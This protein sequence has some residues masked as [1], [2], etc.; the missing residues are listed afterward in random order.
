MSSFVRNFFLVGI[1]FLLSQHA[2]AQR[3]NFENVLVGELGV[4][5]GSSN[6]YGDLNTGADLSHSKVAFG[7]FFRKQFGDYVAVRLTGHYAQL[8]YSDSYSNNEFQR[9]R[10]LSF[11][12]DIYEF[13]IMGDFNFLRYIPGDPYYRFTPYA[14]IGVGIF[15]YDPYTFY[16]GDK[17]Y[18]RP[19]NTE[20]Q[21]FYQDR[22]AYGNTAFSFP[23]AFGIKYAVSDKITL[24]AEL[25]YR[26]TTTDYIDDVSTSFIGINN[27]PSSGGHQSL[28]SIL[29]DRSFEVGQTIGVEGR[30]RGFSKQKDHFSIFEIG[31]SFNIMSYRCPTA[32]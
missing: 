19:L 28:G 10:N 6:Y 26:F 29:Q 24:S 16:Q 1:V 5:V 7:V 8:G 23:I 12:T 27:F 4:T 17:V 31:L 14:S 32:Q 2:I 11:N 3:G 21:T 9:M 13:A 18:L 25:G 22:K 20:G 30:Q 15:S